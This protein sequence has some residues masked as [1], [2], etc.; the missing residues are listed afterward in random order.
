MLLDFSVLLLLGVTRGQVYALINRGELRPFR[1]GARLRFDPDE[2]DELL[3][4]SRSAP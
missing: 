3:E 4:R 2:I 1:V